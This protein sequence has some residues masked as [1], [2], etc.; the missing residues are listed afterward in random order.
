MA[1]RSSGDGPRA[2]C[3]GSFLWAEPAGDGAARSSARSSRHPKNASRLGG[4]SP[5]IPRNPICC[6]FGSIWTVSRAQPLAHGC[7]R[8]TFS[9]P[10]SWVLFPPS[11]GP[12]LSDF[13]LLPSSSCY[14][15][16]PKPIMAEVFGVVSGVVGIAT[17]FTAC[18]ECFG[19]IRLGRNLGRDFQTTQ[20]TL[21]CARLRLSRWGEAVRVYDDQPSETRTPRLPNYRMQRARWY[22]SRA[23]S[24]PPRPSP[25]NIARAPGVTICWSTRSATS[26]PRLLR[27]TTR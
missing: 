17:V 2:G 20:L 24:R 27:C 4:G 15:Y 18:V 19:Y 9:S 25:R 13:S 14:A 3:L 6:S 12:S 1:L 26:S 5:T 22:K 10:F 7:L 16:R 8:V 23:S 21:A 11:P